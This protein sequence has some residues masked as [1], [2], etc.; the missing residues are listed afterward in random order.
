MYCIL[1]VQYTVVQFTVHFEVKKISE[2]VLLLYLHNI[3][4]KAF[5]SKGM[6]EIIRL[7]AYVK[8]YSR[9]DSNSPRFYYF[10]AQQ[11]M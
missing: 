11:F 8:V 1:Y 9:G 2:N 6:T 5:C 10:C 3:L 4:F 7:A